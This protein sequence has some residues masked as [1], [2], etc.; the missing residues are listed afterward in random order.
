MIDARANSD[1]PATLENLMKEVAQ[2]AGSLVESKDLVEVLERILSPLRVPLNLGERPASEII[3]F[4]PEGGSV[5]GVLRGLQPTMKLRE[6]LGFLPLPRHGS[7]L[8]ALLRL[9]QAV[10]QRNNGNPV[11]IV[12][13]FGEDVDLDAALH[14]GSM[15]RMCSG[16]LWLSTRRGALG[17]CFGPEELVRLT[18]SRDAVRRIHVGQVPTTRAERLAARHLHLQILP[19]ISSRAIII[20]EGPHDRAALTT[21]AA[22]LNVEEGTPLPAAYR[23]VLLDAGAADSSG[24]NTAIPRLAT[25]ARNLGFHV[26]ALIDW[27]QDAKVAEDLLKRNIET[28]NVVIRWPQGCAIE[29]ALLTGLEEDIIRLA[30]KEISD[31]LAVP[32]EFNPDKLSNADLIGRATVF[33][34]SAG[35]MHTAFLEALPEKCLPPLIRTC[36]ELMPRIVDQTGVVLQL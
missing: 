14:V 4:V 18:N 13:D 21:A 16:Q 31:A 15:L 20:V 10:A 12:D 1:F 17:Q 25:L 29:R 33:L 5:G 26:T 32:L 24:G 11:I 9:T 2:L 3:R 22:K 8:A 19:A 6:S 23:I 34:K 30:L 27:D 36:L 28:S 35:G 7:T